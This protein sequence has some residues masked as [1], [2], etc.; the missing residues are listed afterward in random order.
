[1]I[2]HMFAYSNKRLY[3]LAV[4]SSFESTLGTCSCSCFSRAASMS[5]SSL[6]A[7]HNRKAVASRLMGTTFHIGRSYWLPIERSTLQVLWLA[8]LVENLMG[9]LF[10]SS[11]SADCLDLHD[12]RE[13]RAR[14]R[15][16]WNLPARKTEDKVERLSGL[17]VHLVHLNATSP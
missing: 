5:V 6:K 9:S 14:D 3:F 11:S 1:M 12:S 16:L 13:L 7:H 4:S 15:T 8:L 2:Q 10:T 17:K